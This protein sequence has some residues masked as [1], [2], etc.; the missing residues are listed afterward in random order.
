MGSSDQAIVTLSQDGSL[1]GEEEPWERCQEVLQDRSRER[2][3][4]FY[5][6]SFPSALRTGDISQIPRVPRAGLR[7]G[8]QFKQVSLDIGM[9]SM[10]QGAGEEGRQIAGL[11]SRKPYSECL[12]LHYSARQM[13]QTPAIRPQEFCLSSVPWFQLPFRL[14][15]S[16]IPRTWSFLTG[17]L[18]FA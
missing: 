6:T 18:S 12:T 7:V 9:R 15:S 10:A 17:L 8:G 2:V 3:S 5:S 16:H 1:L 14:R 11:E 13:A 4:F